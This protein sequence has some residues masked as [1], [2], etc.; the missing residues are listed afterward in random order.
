MEVIVKT[1]ERVTQLAIYASDCCVD[2][3][4][5]D[6]NDRYSRCPKCSRLCSWEFVE[7]VISW[8]EMDDLESVAA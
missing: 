8:H 1:A 7:K 6:V 2:E 4:L 3:V 5:F